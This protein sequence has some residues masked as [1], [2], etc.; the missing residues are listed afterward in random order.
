M[1]I[2]RGEGAEEKRAFI[3]GSGKDVPAVWARSR[4]QAHDAKARGRARDMTQRRG[5]ELET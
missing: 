3:L 2:M 4:T 5:G 1:T